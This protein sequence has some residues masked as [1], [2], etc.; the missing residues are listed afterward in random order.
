MNTSP[1]TVRLSLLA[2]IVFLT[3]CAGPQSI[4]DDAKVLGVFVE[5]L[6]T[7]IAEFTSF[8]DSLAKTRV[9]TINQR[10][11]LAAETQQEIERQLFLWAL[12]DSDKGRAQLYEGVRKGARLIAQ[13]K[14]D[15]DAR[16]EAN[17]KILEQ[18]KSGVQIQ[19]AKLGEASS[20]LLQLSSTPSTKEE[21]EFYAS[22]FKEVRS[23]TEALKKSAKSVS[24]EAQKQTASGGTEK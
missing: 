13:Q 4:R 18:T 9:T 3:A 6:R 7:E 20:A 23:K 17:R 16:T 14:A 19:T 8:R 12:S 1:I 15:L 5:N 11:V 21:I 22:F 2:S 10:D 24:E